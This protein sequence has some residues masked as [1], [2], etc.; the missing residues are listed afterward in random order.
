M[1]PPS[2]SYVLGFE[3]L[4]GVIQQVYY[5]PPR[6]PAELR[7]PALTT[8][9]A[10]LAVLCHAHSPS[11]SL[12]GYPQIHQPLCCTGKGAVGPSAHLLQRRL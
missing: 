9:I 5:R 2:S 4:R 6:R 1:H 12:R 7:Q 10:E 11:A 3:G 8:Q